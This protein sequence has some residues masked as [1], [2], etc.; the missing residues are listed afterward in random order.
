M[1]VL[2]MLSRIGSY[3]VGVTGGAP[4]LGAPDSSLNGRNVRFDLLSGQWSESP[5]GYLHNLDL[6]EGPGAYP[7]FYIL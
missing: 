3:R 4:L 5:V 6:A 1:S 7:H 2:V